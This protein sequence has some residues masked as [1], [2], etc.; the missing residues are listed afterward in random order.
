VI[1]GQQVPSTLY[2]LRSLAR[3]IRQSPTKVEEA[4]ESVLRE[5]EV[6]IYQRAVRVRGERLNGSSYLIRSVREKEFPEPNANEA[7][8]FLVALEIKGV[9]VFKGELESFD[10][11]MRTITS[12]EP[13]SSSFHLPLVAH[14]HPFRSLG[15]PQVQ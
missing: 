15:L 2:F 12:F 10:E 8:F 9:G 7:V 13:S 3:L 6:K 4:V 14:F 5:G 11:T 1:A